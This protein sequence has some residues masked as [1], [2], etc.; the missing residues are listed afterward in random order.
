MTVFIHIAAPSSTHSDSRYR[1]Q[2]DA[3]LQTFYSN[4]ENNHEREHDQETVHNNSPVTHEQDPLPSVRLAPDSFDSPVSVIPESPP[5]PAQHPGKRPPPATS[6][7]NDRHKKH[8]PKEEEKEGK[9]DYPLLIHA[10]PP[11]IAA[12]TFTTHLTPTLS[13]LANRLNL[14][15]TFVPLRQTR[16]LHVLERGY[17]CLRLRLSCSEPVARYPRVAQT[18]ARDELSLT[19]NANANTTATAI[20]T[21]TSTC[22]SNN[23]WDHALFTRFW[24]FLSDL[25]AKEGRAGWGVWCILDRDRDRDPPPPPPSSSHTNNNSYEE[26]VLKVYT[27]GEIAPHIYLLLYLASERRIR[28][29]GAQ[30][31]DASERVVIQMP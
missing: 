26:L 8:R 13:L 10:P 22:A 3:I 21:G 19:T 4:Q 17:W 27:W 6:P 2:A 15:R 7:D 14:A 29:M 9:E 11:P 28:K 30:W 23:T 24:T 16:E 31:R 18:A 20:G 1:A 25:I 5:A 12:N